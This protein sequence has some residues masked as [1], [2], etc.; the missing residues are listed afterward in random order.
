MTKKA[1]DFIKGFNNFFKTDQ[2][3]FK[4]GR[5]EVAFNYKGNVQNIKE[6]LSDGDAVFSLKES[7]LVNGHSVK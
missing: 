1:L 7:D 5:F 4:D 2:F 6:L 3:F